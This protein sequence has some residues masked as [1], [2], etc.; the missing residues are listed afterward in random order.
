MDKDQAGLEAL[1]TWLDD[2]G[3]R[4]VHA[5]IAATGVSWPDVGAAIASRHIPVS[6][7]YPAEIAAFGALSED[8]T[9][10]KI[11]SSRMIAAYC[12][13]RNPAPW[14]GFAHARH[15]PWIVIATPS[16]NAASFID[17]TIS[18]VVSQRGNFC[19][20]YH[21]QDGGSTD[22]TIE[23]LQRWESLLRG[24]NPLGG[25]HVEFSWRSGPDG[26]IYDAINAGLAEAYAGFDDEARLA[27][28]MTWL[29]ASDLLSVRCLQTVSSFFSQYPTIQW[30]TGMVANLDEAGGPII[31]APDPQVYAQRYLASG[32]HDG[33]TIR[34]IQQEGTFWRYALWQKSGGL[35]HH[36][37]LAGDWDLWRRFAFEAPVVKLESIL[38]TSRRHLGQLSSDLSA[39]CAEI[40][41]APRMSDA[42]VQA[43]SNF[44]L[45]AVY[46]ETTHRWN[47]SEVRVLA[48][49]EREFT[50]SEALAFALEQQMLG[51]IEVAEAVWGQLF[52]VCATDVDALHHLGMVS[53]ATG[54]SQRA[55][56]AL[57]R[58]IAL[59][60]RRPQLH[61]DAGKALQALGR[62]NEAVSEYQL[63]LS[64]RPDFAEASNNL[65]VA[66]RLHAAE[67]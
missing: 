47:L 23:A 57:G 25:A 17:E 49:N 65:E 6:L 27:T 12:F 20:R 11:F 66:L 31:V 55:I 58:A 59:D 9:T 51:H 5:C 26:G 1:V 18:S 38:A 14:V 44:G 35:S 39:Y 34:C 3:A 30:I 63:A 7:V 42:E 21:V 2:E 36:F 33:R 46:E 28:V 19:I 52:A 61:N 29:G 41:A 16:Y 13:E 62:V 60:G 50:L 56:E 43:L 4:T 15:M 8:C 48:P 53:L 22:G 32:A 37:R 67:G 54:N 10:G 45:K 24:P 40:D 64:L